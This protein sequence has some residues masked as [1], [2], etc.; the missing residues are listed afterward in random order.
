MR[1]AR[2]KKWMG[3]LALVKLAGGGFQKIP[4]GIRACCR[5]QMGRLSGFGG[6]SAQ[7]QLKW[8]VQKMSLFS[9]TAH[10]ASA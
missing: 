1:G 6:A 5:A 10:A 4:A 9:S 2:A 8:P 3:K 7:K